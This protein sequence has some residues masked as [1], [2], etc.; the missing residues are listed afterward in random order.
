MGAEV[1][2]TTSVFPLTESMLSYLAATGRKD[3]ADTI[4]A[5]KEIRGH[6]RADEGCHYD[7]VIEINLDELEP[8]INGPFTPDLATPLSQF[9]EAVKKNQWPE[10]I[11]VSTRD[12]RPR[13]TT[14]DT[15]T[16]HTRHTHVADSHMVGVAGGLD[17]KLYQ[18]VLRGHVP[19]RRHRAPGQ[20]EGHQGAERLHRHARY[21][22]CCVCGGACRVPCAMCHVS[23]VRFGLTL[24]TLS[25][26]GTDQSHY[27][28]RRPDAGSA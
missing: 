22:P 10:K 24:N 6:L 15:H 19:R 9:A 28:A 2:A 4:T 16:T 1:G 21:A 5:A 25:R 23:C 8:Y 12:R 7:E 13:H 27:R 3:I 17:R 20:R 18:L 26:V 14:H 11:S